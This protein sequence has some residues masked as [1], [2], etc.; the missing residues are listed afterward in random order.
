MEKIKQ[1]VKDHKKAVIGALVG[2]GGAA[3]CAITYHMG[4]RKGNENTT[5]ICM[6]MLAADLDGTAML[7]ESCLS[8][9]SDDEM[10]EFIK[11]GHELL[12]D[13]NKRIAS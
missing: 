2:A 4:L 10:K 12:K 9:L 13:A 7:V 3:A 6:A 5:A 1:F 8:D 11:C